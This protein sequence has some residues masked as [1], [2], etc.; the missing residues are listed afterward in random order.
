MPTEHEYKYAISLEIA[1][2]LDHP[3]LLKIAKE[4]QHIKQGYLAFSKGMT[5]R[6][7]GIQDGDKHRWFLTFKQKVENRVIEIEK[8]LDDRDGTDLWSVCVGKLKK[9][10]YV[11]ED[12]GIT[13]ELDFFKKG[14]HLYF[15]LAEVELPEGASRPKTIPDFFKNYVLYEVPLT[16]DRFSNKRLAEVEFATQLYS[17]LT[18]GRNDVINETEDLSEGL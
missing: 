11:I 2:D 9:D 5:T 3:T 10:R 8:K 1:N 14:H 4:H 13:W 16:D 15:V 17:E 18:N 7:R 6:I 12:K